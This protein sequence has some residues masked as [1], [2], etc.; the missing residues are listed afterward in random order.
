MWFQKGPTYFYFDCKKI[1]FWQDILKPIE[2]T[3][4]GISIT[5]GRVHI[6]S[7]H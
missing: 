1:Y 2:N 4:L 6:R 7:D 3:Q 5:E